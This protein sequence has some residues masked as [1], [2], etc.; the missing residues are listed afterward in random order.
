MSSRQKPRSSG[1]HGIPASAGM[2]FSD[3]LATRSPGT[4]QDPLS[5]TAINVPRILR[6]FWLKEDKFHSCAILHRTKKIYCL[7]VQNPLYARPQRPSPGTRGRWV[8]ERLSLGT[9]KA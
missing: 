1:Y 5:P 7:L 4:Q 2:T 8:D 6:D 9:R 3:S